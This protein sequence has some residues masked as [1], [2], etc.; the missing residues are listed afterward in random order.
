MAL[1]TQ[2]LPKPTAC[3]KQRNR[4]LPAGAY[5]APANKAFTSGVRML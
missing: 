3:V 4:I 5:L 2:A 1:K